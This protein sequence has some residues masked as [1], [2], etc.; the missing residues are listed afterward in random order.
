MTRRWMPFSSRVG[1]IAV[2]QRMDVR[3]LGDPGAFACT[4]EGGLHRID[5]GRH[6]RFSGTMPG[7]SPPGSREDPD[8]GAMRPPEFPQHR[9]DL[10][11]QGDVAILLCLAVDVEQH[12]GAVDVAD[13]QASAFGEAQA[14][15]VDRGQ[16]G[17]VGRDADLLEDR[18]DL[19]SAQDHG[20]TFL[21]LGSDDVEDAPC[22]LEG[23]FV[24][25]LD[26]AQGDGDRSASELLDV[27]EVEEV[28]AEFLLG[29]RI[30]RLSV[31]AS[32]LADGAE[33]GLLSSCAE[34]V[35]LHIL[36]HAL[37]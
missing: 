6:A 5:A 28:L 26:A 29:D 20:E 8:R 32:Q 31:V 17:A 2:A 4:A 36:D 24:E 33:V 35:E 27:D 15:G 12:A 16:A 7:V 19:L 34:P 18:V 37:T 30:G 23:L 13:L 21:L 3:F 14:T 9:E 25:E 1:S 22:T 10:L 11:R